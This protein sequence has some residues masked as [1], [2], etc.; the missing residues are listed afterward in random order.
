MAIGQTKGGKIF[1]TTENTEG[2]GGKRS[3]TE[4]S[5]GLR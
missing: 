4:G 2:H 3:E 1:V 5:L